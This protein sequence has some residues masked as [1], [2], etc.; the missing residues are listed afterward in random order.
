MG[1]LKRFNLMLFFVIVCKLIW[2]L[3]NKRQRIREIYEK[4]INFL[5]KISIDKMIVGRAPSEFVMGGKNNKIS[6]S[7]S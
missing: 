6:D 5:F 1:R 7:L 4:N 2:L 3:N